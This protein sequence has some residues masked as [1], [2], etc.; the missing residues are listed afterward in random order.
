MGE[1]HAP[2]GENPKKAP[3][4]VRLESPDSTSREFEANST[5]STP[6]WKFSGDEINIH[7][8]NW[9]FSAIIIAG[10]LI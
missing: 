6:I 9:K 7:P 1:G 5:N 2:T 10:G 8:K 3:R 4:I